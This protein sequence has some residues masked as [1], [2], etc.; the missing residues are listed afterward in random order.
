MLVCATVEE[1]R[2]MTKEPVI[3]MEE[4][5]L[6]LRELGAAEYWCRVRLKKLI[7]SGTAKF[8]GKKS[9]RMIDGRRSHSPVY[10]LTEVQNGPKD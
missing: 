3:T 8:N 1:G 7:K 2:D 10:I 5:E 4:L 6:Q 9:G